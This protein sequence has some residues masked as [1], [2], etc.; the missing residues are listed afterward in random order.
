M[1]DI[2]RA[3]LNGITP[4]PAIDPLVKDSASEARAVARVMVRL[5]P[6]SIALY[7]LNYLDRVNVSFAKLDMNREL[8]FSEAVYG[9]GA[10]IFFIGYFIFEVP[11]NLI[12]QRVGARLWIA[13]IMITWGI[14]AA[15]MMFVR[16]KGSFYLLR[17]L[18]GAAEAGFFP[19]ILLYFTYWVPASHR[20]RVGAWFFTSLALAGMI[21]G[22]IAGI[23]MKAH[24]LG[25]AGWRWLFVLEGVPT[26][27]IGFLVLAIL[28]N[29]PDEVSWLDNSEKAALNQAILGEQSHQSKDGHRLRFAFASPTVW[30]L[31]M[32]YGLIL[33]ALYGLG[34]WTPSII[35]QVS[36]HTTTMVGWLSA[37]PFGAAILGMLLVGR[38]TD[39]LQIR[40]GAV[41]FC[42]LLGA[43]GMA[44]CAIATSTAGV[45]AFLCLAAIGVLG[46]LGPFWT[47]PP[48]I[49]RGPAAAAG[50]AI[51]NSVGNLGGGFVGPNVMGQLREQH[52]SYE[53]GLF[54]NASV[55]LVAA[56]VAML[57]NF[58]K[59]CPENVETNKM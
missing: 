52:H 12:L 6:L 51:I 1:S 50:I 15:A 27:L 32:Q 57:F 14:I 45:V 30:I 58:R 23:L 2:M 18:L 7:V 42:A 21:G 38:I 47:L 5:V 26:I 54:V 25:L 13:R 29:R 31:S 8:G 36:G 35:Q 16:G 59:T 10:S 11:S 37:I 22:P 56:S 46:S 24:Y 55:L 39:V 43:S 3:E 49:L 33:F 28:P 4:K 20:A 41:T 34:Y 48:A 17:F 44:G 40:R 53:L 19:G 9:F